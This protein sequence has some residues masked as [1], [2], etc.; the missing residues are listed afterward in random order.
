MVAIAVRRLTGRNLMGVD[1]DGPSG[2]D[3]RGFARNDFNAS[4]LRHLAT[5]AGQRSATAPMD[6][7]RR[8]QE[9]GDDDRDKVWS[10]TGW[11]LGE[12]GVWRYE[13]D[14]SQ[15]KLRDLAP[16]YT[17][18]ERRQ[19][20]LGEMLDH[21]ALFNAYPQLRDTR[22][23]L[24]E[25][26]IGTAQYSGHLSRAEQ[27]ADGKPRIT[28]STRQTPDELL[29]T[30]LHEGQH[31]IEDIE[32]FDY[33]GGNVDYMRMPGEIQARNV[34]R[35]QQFSPEERRAIAP[36]TTDDSAE[37]NR[38]RMTAREAWKVF[39]KGSAGDLPSSPIG[40]AA[41]FHEAWADDPSDA[42]GEAI[43]A[44]SQHFGIAP[45]WEAQ[46]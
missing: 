27:N 3:L 15:A 8:A 30:I 33:H 12:D 28:L 9:R 32:G 14:D 34:E 7:L 11:M 20:T 45:P 25:G 35:R 40:L 23:D 46:R 41:K 22:V 13:I 36:W 29:N 5:F 21:P 6:D 26:P 24:Q 31:A 10:D 39:M 4:Q 44:L 38:G 16:P 1:P 42:I 18:N 19:T 43:E 2:A 17:G 37:V